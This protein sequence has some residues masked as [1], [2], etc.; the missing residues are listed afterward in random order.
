VLRSY[1]RDEGG[2]LGIGLHGQMLSPNR[3]L[4]VIPRQSVAGACEWLRGI[5]HRGHDLQR[6]GRRTGEPAGSAKGDCKGDGTLS[7]RVPMDLAGTDR[8]V[9][10]EKRKTKA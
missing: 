9:V 10:A 5:R 1:V 7:G 2:P 3:D 6:V 8:L 4:D